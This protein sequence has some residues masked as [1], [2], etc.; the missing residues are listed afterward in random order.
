MN[1]SRGAGR[2][3]NGQSTP[4]TRLSRTLSQPN[5]SSSINSVV[6]LHGFGASALSM[7]WFARQLERCGFE[8][9][10]WSYPSFRTSIE[11]LGNQF[12]DFLNDLAGSADK[13]GVVAHSMGSAIVRSSL[14]TLDPNA[15][16]RCVFLAPPILGTPVVRILPGFARRIFPPLEQLVDHPAGYVRNLPLPDS[17]AV[18]SGRLDFQVP[19]KN[20]GAEMVD[21]HV[22]LYVTHNSI[23]FS[24][25]A[26]KIASRFLRT[27]EFACGG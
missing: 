23:L 14:E 16:R 12:S 1:R 4:A 24:A 6:L 19:T 9:H 25:Q 20:T 15:L 3:W 7:R 11:I 5:V 13:V 8:S 27:G 22:S 18:V 26:V 2:L 21:N 10:V 17:L